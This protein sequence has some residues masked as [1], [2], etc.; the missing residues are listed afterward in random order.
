MIEHVKDAIVAQDHC[1]LGVLS[2][3]FDLRLVNCSSSGCLLETTSYIEVG[4]VGTLRLRL[5]GEDFSE[6]VQ[7]VRCQKIAGAGSLHHVGAKFLWTALPVNGSLRR[8][9]RR[10]SPG[11][12]IGTVIR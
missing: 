4:T 5:D 8:A 2:R 11:L 12:P 10:G 3:E 9:M 6:Q 7:V 1:Q